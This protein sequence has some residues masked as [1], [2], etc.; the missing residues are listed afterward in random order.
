M[1]S[2]G[3]V[4]ASRSAGS[5]SPS[6]RAETETFPCFVCKPWSCKLLAGDNVHTSS[7]LALMLGIAVE[8]LSSWGAK[9]TRAF[10]PGGPPML[11][12]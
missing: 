7:T 10:F 3:P 5:C 9:A 11:E 4:L 1:S 8:D 6:E 12:T 2:L